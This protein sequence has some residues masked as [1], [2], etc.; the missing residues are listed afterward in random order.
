MRT[1]DKYTDIELIE[2]SKNGDQQAFA[3]L[4]ERYRIIA[5]KHAYLFYQDYDKAQ[6]VTQDVFT[7]LWNKRETLHITSNFSAYLHR[8]VRH[9]ILNQLDHQKIAQK[10]YDYTEAQ[11]TTP[12]NDVDEYIIEKELTAI[13]YNKIDKLPKKMKEVFLLSREEQK[14]HQEISEQ[15][16]ITTKTVRQQIYNALLILK[17][18]LKYIFIL[19]FSSF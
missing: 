15:L 16:N 14:S 8:M 13:L 11:Q 9:I 3:I 17:S 18:N 2:L 10:F 6:D 7:K 1:D 12:R 19:L 5:Y 4:Y